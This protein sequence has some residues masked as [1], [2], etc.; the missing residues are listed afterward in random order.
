[1]WKIPQAERIDWFPSSSAT[2]CNLIFKL[3]RLNVIHT[4][5]HTPNTHPL[6]LGWLI[7]GRLAVVIYKFSFLLSWWRV[8]LKAWDSPTIVL[9]K[10]ACPNTTGMMLFWRK[11]QVFEKCTLSPFIITT[12]TFF[13]WSDSNFSPSLH[14]H[15]GWQNPPSLVLWYTKGMAF[16][17][18]SWDPAPSFVWCDW[19]KCL[20]FWEQNYS[21]SCSRKSMDSMLASVTNKLH[22]SGKVT[23]PFWVLI[24]LAEELVSC[25][26]QCT[27]NFHKTKNF[28]GFLWLPCMLSLDNLS[29]CWE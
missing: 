17:W 23:D 6:I 10:G 27:E 28:N 4:H 29:A 14:F 26:W 1:M 2:A 13:T 25:V 20:A 24:C 21:I 16:S 11:S 9:R 18:T 3:M 19:T 15:R 7:W 22:D 8:V 5:K 12:A